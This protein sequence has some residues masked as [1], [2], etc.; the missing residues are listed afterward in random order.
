MGISPEDTKRLPLGQFKARARQNFRKL[1]KIHP[2]RHEKEAG[3]NP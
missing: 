2:S 1:G 3:I